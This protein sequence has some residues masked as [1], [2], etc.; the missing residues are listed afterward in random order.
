MRYT[1]GMFGDDDRDAAPSE[2]RVSPGLV[3]L[4]VAAALLV[5]FM[6]QNTNRVRVEFLL[7]D[8]TVALW[9]LVLAS[10]AAGALVGGG[11]SALRRRRRR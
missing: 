3:A 8:L 10:A 5:A 6:V 4:V 11:L 9:L 1:V 2:S 7:W